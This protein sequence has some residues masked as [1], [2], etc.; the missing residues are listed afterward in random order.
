M[1]IFGE[2]Q[3]VSYWSVTSGVHRH[4]ESERVR[5]PNERNDGAAPPFGADR[6]GRLCRLLLP[7]QLICVI[8]RYFDKATF[9]NRA[10]MDKNSINFQ[11]YHRSM[12]LEAW[13]V[14]GRR[15]LEELSKGRKRWVLAG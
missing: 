9:F 5:A 15:D 3:E 10:Y 14:D 13:F 1:R 2:Q 12:Q 6:I 8:P 7:W 4:N 11:L